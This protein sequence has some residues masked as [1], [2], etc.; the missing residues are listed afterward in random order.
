MI[1]ESRESILQQRSAIRRK[2]DVDGRLGRV[3]VTKDEE[4]RDAI[5]TCARKPT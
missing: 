4:I 1:P 2:V 5:L 3:S